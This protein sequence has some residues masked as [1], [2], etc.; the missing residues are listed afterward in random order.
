MA[1]RPDSP[2][3]LPF[4]QRPDFAVEREAMSAGLWPL[5][6]VD[7]AGRGPLAGPVVAAAVILDPA[8]I[9]EGLDDSKRLSPAQ[10]ERLFD[11][12]MKTALAVSVASLPA[13]AIDRLNVLQASFSAMCRAL[14]GLSLPPRLALVDGHLLPA[15]MVCEGRAIVG[16]D[17]RSQSIAAASVVAKVFRDRMMDVCGVSDTRYGF[18]RHMGYPTAEHRGAL[19][20]HGPMLRLHRRSFAPLRGEQG[21]REASAQAAASLA[22]DES[23]AKA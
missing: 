19:A 5:A 14:A 6:G 2:R 18:Q 16:G 12:V 23:S 10:R 9:P 13:E 4:P 11:A 3:S 17:G 15:G 22:E 20:R 7:E 21:G 1:R 8:R